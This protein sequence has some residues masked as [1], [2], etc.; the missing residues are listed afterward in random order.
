LK[1]KREA[2]LKKGLIFIAVFLIAG[3]LFLH[4]VLA[5][6]SVE[7]WPKT[8]S[9]NLDEQLTVDTNAIQ[10]DLA[11]KVIG[12]KIFEIVKQPFRVGNKKIVFETA[13]RSPG[14]RIIIV[15]NGK[16]LLTKE[17]RTEHKKYDYRLPGGK[18]FNTLEEYRKLLKNNDNILPFAIKAAKKEC[19][20]EA[21]IIANKIKYFQTAKAGATVEWDLFYFI[22]DNFN[23]FVYVFEVQ[24]GTYVQ[25][26]RVDSLFYM[27]H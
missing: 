9:L 23:I 13:R 24:T 27:S 15:K 1:G 20:E 14:A 8:E 6:V 10:L 12:G 17:F 4:F 26:K 5:K 22:V 16:I 3:L 19:L 2:V 25:Y 7:I 18:I 21:G 11:S